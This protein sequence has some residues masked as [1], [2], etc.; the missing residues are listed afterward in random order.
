LKWTAGEK[1]KTAEV[2]L[3]E[4]QVNADSWAGGSPRGEEQERMGN[5]RW[6]NFLQGS[7]RK[8]GMNEAVAVKLG[9]QLP[10]LGRSEM[11]IT[12]TTDIRK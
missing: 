10:S 2:C 3:W 6:A 12:D 1:E 4:A 7:G 5:M 8:Q 11:S 9:F